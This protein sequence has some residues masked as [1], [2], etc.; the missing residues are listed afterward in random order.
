MNRHQRAAMAA[1]TDAIVE[2]GGYHAPGGSW[3]DL[4]YTV[5]TAVLRAR[6]VLDS[7]ARRL[8]GAAGARA[9]PCVLTRRTTLE[10]MAE[11]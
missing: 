9:L 8:S 1:E 5:E 11:G 10:A 3:I 7:E 4:S 2:A 6:H